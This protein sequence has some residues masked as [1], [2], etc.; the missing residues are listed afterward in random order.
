MIPIKETYRKLISLV[1]IQANREGFKRASKLGGQYDLRAI[2]EANEVEKASYRV[3]SIYTDD[4][5]KEAKEARVCI[6]KHRSG[7]TTT[8]P[9]VVYVDPV[10]YY[11]GDEVSGSFI[12]SDMDGSDFASLLGES[13]DLFI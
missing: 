12:G 5:M 4:Y 2:S 3:F 9:L 1:N 8:E 6:L 7:K 13:G 11:I 10:C